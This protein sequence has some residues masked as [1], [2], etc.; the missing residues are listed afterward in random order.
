MPVI[1]EKVHK[2][3][4]AS[5]S[6]VFVKYTTLFGQTDATSSFISSL[7]TA[8]TILQARTLWFKMM[9]AKKFPGTCSLSEFQP[10]ISVAVS[11]ILIIKEFTSSNLLLDTSAAVSL[12]F[13]EVVQ[14]PLADRQTDI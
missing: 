7:S 2:L 1:E 8:A 12:V 9:S 5:A 10:H 14:Y 4:S 11:L 3:Y 6:I 13:E